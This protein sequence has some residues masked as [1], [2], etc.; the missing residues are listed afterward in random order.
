MRRM[1]TLL[2]CLV[3]GGMAGLLGWLLA[4]PNPAAVELAQTREALTNAQLKIESLEADRS[5]RGV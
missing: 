3:L 4:R 5:A 2:L 1:K